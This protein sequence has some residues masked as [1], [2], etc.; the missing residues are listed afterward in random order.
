MKMKKFIYKIILFVIIHNMDQINPFT[1]APIN[2]SA[3]PPSPDKSAQQP[4][5]QPAGRKKIEFDI[6][7]IVK[8]IVLLLIGVVIAKLAF[9]SIIP[10]FKPKPQAVPMPKSVTPARQVAT[11]AA[12]AKPM[13]DKAK[14]ATAEQSLSDTFAAAKKLRGHLLAHSRPRPTL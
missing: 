11:P 2:P 14:K 9:D 6:K 5:R 13:Q 10:L 7:Y 8:S 4:Q 12:A 3:Q 1:N